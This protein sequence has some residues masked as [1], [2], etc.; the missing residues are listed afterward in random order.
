MAWVSWVP[1]TDTHVQSKPWGIDGESAKRRKAIRQT[2]L[3][4]ARATPD[5]VVRFVVGNPS[6]IDGERALQKEMKRYPSDFISVDVDVRSRQLQI[7]VALCTAPAGGGGKHFSGPHCATCSHKC[8]HSNRQ[9][10]IVQRLESP[11]MSLSTILQAGM[12]GAS[13]SLA[14]TT[15]RVW[16]SERVLLIAEP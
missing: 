8:C 4:R 3:P 13:L 15:A 5:V 16:K 7:R 10:C 1:I 9:H 2:W 12:G 14:A 11:G 6:E